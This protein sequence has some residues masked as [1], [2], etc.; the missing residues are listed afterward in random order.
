MAPDFKKYTWLD[1]GSDERQYCAPGVD[2]PIASIMRSKYGESPEYHTS[3]D[4]LNFVTPSGLFGS[5]SALQQAIQIIERN[6]SPKSTVLGEPQLG[7]RGLYPTLSTRDSGLQVKTIMDMISYC[8]GKHSILDIAEILD[9][10]F[11]KLSDLLG[12]LIAAGLI[13]IEMYRLLRGR[14]RQISLI[15]EPQRPQLAGIGWD[16]IS[17]FLDPDQRGSA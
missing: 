12:P 15:P 17:S 9:Q 13:N 5:F 10:P 16:E 6:G 2:L 11:A 1:R 4:D 3:L 8:D 7:K 14:S